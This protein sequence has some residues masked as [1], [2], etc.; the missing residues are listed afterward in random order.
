VAFIEVYK[1]ETNG[2]SFETVATEAEAA[3]AA[4]AAAAGGGHPEI[5]T[6][7]LKPNI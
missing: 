3:A 2:L 7:R 1:G 6:V 4:A 5:L